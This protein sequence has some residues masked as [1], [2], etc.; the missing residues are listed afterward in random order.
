[1][2]T[3][4][5]WPFYSPGKSQ[6]GKSKLL[7]NTLKELR[8]T[9]LACNSNLFFQFFPSRSNPAD[10][11]SR[12]LSDK[13]CMLSEES[14]RPVE[15]HFG[16]HSID[17]IS[18]DSNTQVDFQGC[19]L[20][21]FTPFFTPQSSGVNMFAQPIAPSENAYV[22][23]PFTLITPVLN[24][25]F[26]LVVTRLFPLPLWWPALFAHAQE[27]FRLGR[28]GESGVI[29]FPS[30]TGNFVTR[31]LQWGLLVFRVPKCV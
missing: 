1:M 23:P 4:I 21:H 6:G 8:K 28:K 19:P 18:L 10:S 31:P 17:L 16:P 9:A 2:F 22:F 5:C 7:S 27:H 13:D 12:Q 25:L 26:S 15:H 14:W 30:S 24:F 11:S 29:L 20:K 3:S